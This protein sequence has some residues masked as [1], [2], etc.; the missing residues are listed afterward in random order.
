MFNTIGNLLTQDDQVRCFGN[1]AR[2]LDDDGLFVLECRVPTAP[3]RPACQ[4]VEPEQVGLDHVVLGVSRYD[5]VSQILDM[6]HVRIGGEGIVFGPIRLR[7]ANPPEFD[8]M[9]RITA[10]RLHDRWAGWHEEPL[11]RRQLATRQRLQAH[12]GS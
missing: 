4:F 6:N 11:H 1:A 12:D 2:H 3:T 10:L 8:L 9:A 5:P 7:L